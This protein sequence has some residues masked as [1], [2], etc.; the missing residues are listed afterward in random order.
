MDSF[1]ACF[2]WAI[3]ELKEINAKVE[4]LDGKKREIILELI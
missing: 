4:E 2:E 1:E 3:N